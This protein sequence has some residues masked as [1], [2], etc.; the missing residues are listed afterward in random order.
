MRL[1][2]GFVLCAEPGVD[3]DKEGIVYAKRVFNEQMMNGRRGLAGQ[4]KAGW[5]KGCS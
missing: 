5:L 2:L 4:M 1:L 3:T